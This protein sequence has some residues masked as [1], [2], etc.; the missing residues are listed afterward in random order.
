MRT[1]GE[2]FVRRF[3]SCQRL[4]PRDRRKRV[5]E[6]VEGVASL[7]VIDQVAQ[8]DSSADKD[9]RPAQDFTIAVYN[10]CL[11]RHWEPEVS[12]IAGL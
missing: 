4:V 8:W 12:I 10:E 6:L 5:E 1:F 3:Q 2:R 9:R 7:E 11:F